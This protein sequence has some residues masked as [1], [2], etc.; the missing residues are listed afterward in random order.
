M[1]TLQEIYAGMMMLIDRKRY[2]RFL[3]FVA[4]G[5]R[6]AKDFESAGGDDLVWIGAPDEGP[7]APDRAP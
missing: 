2:L 7:G 1:D 4:S 5:P 3:S 6:Y